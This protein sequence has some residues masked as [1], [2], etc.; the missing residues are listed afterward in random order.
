MFLLNYVILGNQSNLIKN[1]YYHIL[2]SEI[3]KLLL[4]LVLLFINFIN[5][6]SNNGNVQIEMMNIYP[7]Q[8][9]PMLDQNSQIYQTSPNKIKA[10]ELHE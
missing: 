7:N 9:W 3:V 6:M 5:L 10:K 4:L 1:K 2:L 8:Q